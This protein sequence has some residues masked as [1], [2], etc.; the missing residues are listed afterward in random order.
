MT[1]DADF[2]RRSRLELNARGHRYDAAMERVL[3]LYETDR[4]AHDA[5]P[6]IL[7]DRASIYADL[8]A[9]YTAAVQAGAIPD[10]RGPD[11]A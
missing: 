2:S 10:D 3:H 5:L 4:S 11:S 7:R 8:K 6:L 1:H 9:N